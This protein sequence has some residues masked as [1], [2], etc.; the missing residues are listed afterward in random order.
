MIKYI[1]PARK[2]SKGFPGK[3]LKLLNFTLDTIPK[4]EYEN[5][6]ISTDDEKIM[7]NAG[8]LNI[9][10][11]GSQLSDDYASMKDVLLNI[12]DEKRIQD[13]DVVVLLYLTY[14]ERTW[15]D[16]QDALKSFHQSGTNSLLC[17]QSPK[18]HPY[19]CIYEN[20]LQV[21]YHNLYRRQDY[22]KV[23]EISHFVFIATASE[24][25]YLNKNLYNP[26]TFWHGIRDVSDID[27]EEDLGKTGVVL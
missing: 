2:G 26:D 24:I 10:K 15:K 12:I 3:N 4:Y 18:T 14:P 5:T 27:Y 20:G 1:I 8:M 13:T 19:L 9:H 23:F 16:I 22:P 17:R 25:K 7:F 21:A 11:R 6:I